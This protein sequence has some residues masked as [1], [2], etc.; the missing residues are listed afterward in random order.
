MLLVDEAGGDGFGDEFAAGTDAEL[1]EDAAHVSSDGAGADLQ[2]EGDGF[3]GQPLGDETDDFL[4]AGAEVGMTGDRAAAGDVNGIADVIER[5]LAE[6]FILGGEQADLIDPIWLGANGVDEGFEQ[7]F[8]I[9]VDRG[10]S[11]RV[12]LVS[13][14]LRSSVW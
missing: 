8:D 3:V 6:H 11:H 14:I 2:L 12:I 1:V 7:F 10:L 4:L 5:D 13:S 9:G